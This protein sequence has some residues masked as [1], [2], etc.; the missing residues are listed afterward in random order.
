MEAPT[1]GEER[2]ADTSAHPPSIHG[3]RTE[4][5]KGQPL[6]DTTSK[7]KNVLTDIEKIK[8]PQRNFK[9]KKRKSKEEGGGGPREK[10]LYT[11]THQAPE[12]W[13]LTERAGPRKDHGVRNHIQEQIKKGALKVC[14]IKF[15]RECQLPEGVVIGEKA[16]EH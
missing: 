13:E 11:T 7:A 10:W 8:E 16:P 1:G 4:E 2:S 5:T 14:L 3:K 15:T 9:A 12:D 6:G